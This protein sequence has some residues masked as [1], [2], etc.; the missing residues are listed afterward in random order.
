[1]TTPSDPTPGSAVA[2]AMPGSTVP[3]PAEVSASRLPELV[4]AVVVHG[5]EDLRVEQVPT[6]APG[7]GE[8]L[9]QIAYVGICGS[10]LHYYRHGRVGAFEVVEPLVVGHEI[11]GVIIADGGPL[12][13]ADA[14]AQPA[15]GEGP[16]APGTPVTL[17]PASP[18]T[19]EP[20]IADRPNIWPG[21]R[22]LGSA[23]TR[24]HTQ[25]AAQQLVVARRDQVRV[26]PTEL[27][28]RRA[29]LAEPLAVGLHAL[30]RA[31]R[32]AG[33]RVLVSGAGPI[34]LLAAG[35]AVAL[36]ARVTVADVLSHPLTVARQLGVAA[37]V[38]LTEEQ[39]VAEGYDIVLECAG[40]PAALDTAIRSVRRGGTVVAVGLLPGEA[41]PY[42]LAPVVA[43][44]IDLKGSFRFDEELDE[45]IDLLAAHPELELVVT[46]SFPLAQALAAFDR[47]ADP[48]SSSKVLLDLR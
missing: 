43:R 2:S 36:G 5:A 47:A 14:A 39:P 9:I 40:V 29:A 15:R 6:P 4:L 27:S 25:G 16:F 24:P 31:G 19:C 10:D 7:P 37:V 48:S 12:V 33:Q 46:D 21:A 41:R 20:E 11:S 38:D 32:V 30:H 35:A 13:P 42:A 18:G 44:E 26:L 17:H 34:G 23:A 22:Y 45:A 28:L 1:M 3:N 8:V